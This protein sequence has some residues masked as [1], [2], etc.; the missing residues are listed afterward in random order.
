MR[1]S[2]LK[3]YP[4]Q[5]ALP[6]GKA[7]LLSETPI[8]TARREAEEEIGLPG[9]EKSLPPPFKIEHLCQLPLNLAATELGVRPCVAFLHSSDD[10]G[11]D[12]AFVEETLIPRLDAKE[13]AAVFSAPLH[14][15]LK[16]T[17]E[18]PEGEENTAR[19]DVSD[20]YEGDW[21]DWHETKFPMHNFHVPIDGHVV[22]KPKADAEGHG[23]SAAATH[24]EEAEQAGLLRRYR[25]F[26]MTARILV[27]A[28]RVAYEEEPEFEHSS[29]FGDEDMIK[30]LLK[31]GRLAEK[32]RSTDKLKREDTVKAAKM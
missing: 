2:T 26:G 3:S 14:N 12:G 29:H 6:G 16:K 18:I 11:N 27:D 20:W 23:R 5:A 24:L 31:T 32:R 4:G 8:E 21:I 22:Q 30:R 9:N 1:A 7:D 15:F 19:R 28:A 25:V 13:V 17:D 10:V